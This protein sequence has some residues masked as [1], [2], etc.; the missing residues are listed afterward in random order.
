MQ[1]FSR[2]CPK[3]REKGIRPFGT[4]KKIN[5]LS[6]LFSQDYH[7]PLG[8]FFLIPNPYFLIWFRQS[9]ASC[10]WHEQISIPILSNSSSHITNSQLL[11][12]LLYEIIPTV[13][14]V[15][16]S[17]DLWESHPKLFDPW[18]RGRW[19]FLRPFVSQGHKCS[20]SSLSFKKWIW[21]HNTAMFVSMLFSSPPFPTRKQL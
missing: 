16:V 5:I 7:L 20:T 1:V 13:Y 21:I 9:L 12:F 2:Q 3:K 11:G 10:D 6:L 15:S 8:F 14:V 18:R 17:S 19:I 4:R